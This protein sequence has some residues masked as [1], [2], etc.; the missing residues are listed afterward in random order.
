MQD[1][2]TLSEAAELLYERSPSGLTGSPRARAANVSAMCSSGKLVSI[3]DEKGRPLVSR[4]SVENYQF[5][6]R[7]KSASHP[8]SPEDY[9]RLGVDPETY[10]SVGE[11]CRIC[12]LRPDY[13]YQR[14]D[15]DNLTHITRGGITFLLRS[16]LPGNFLS[17]DLHEMPSTYVTMRAVTRE[18]KVP[19]NFVLRVYRKSPVYK[20]WHLYF[21][22]KVLIGVYREQVK[23]I[24]EMYQ[25]RPRKGY[26][27]HG[28][29][30]G[31]MTRKGVSKMFGITRQAVYQAARA[32]NFEEVEHEGV[33]YP[34]CE[35]V[36][37]WARA[38][39]VL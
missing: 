29:P 5:V 31:C 23:T 32:G 30:D 26:S 21:S 33:K 9:L 36:M 27:E 22:K 6:R 16:E 12:T 18:Y 28:A 15:N 13:I 20:P 34:V 38:R 1:W 4:E 37:A 14:V 2:L 3:R 17:W 10:I 24:V 19:S 39:G 35:S 7:S 11:L 25:N 8:A